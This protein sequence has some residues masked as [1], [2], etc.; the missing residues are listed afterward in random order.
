MLTLAVPQSTFFLWLLTALIFALVLPLVVGWVKVNRYYGFFPKYAGVNQSFW[1]RFH[2]YHGGH[3]LSSG[4][5][6]FSLGLWNWVRPLDERMLYVLW[7]LTL[8][9]LLVPSWI[10]I[11]Y[12]LKDTSS[13]KSNY[14][15]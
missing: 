8:V 14:T 10:L 12:P 4:I 7:F 3:F 6:I 11:R 13:A 15:T 1:Q 5:V 2:L 9:S